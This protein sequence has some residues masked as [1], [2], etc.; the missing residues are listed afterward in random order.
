MGYIGALK[1]GLV[2]LDRMMRTQNEKQQ[3]VFDQSR[4]FDLRTRLDT[5]TGADADVDRLLSEVLGIECAGCS[6]DAESSR[7]LVDQLLPHARLQV[8]YDVSGILPGA[9]LHDGAHRYSAVAPTVP[10]AILRVLAEA[11][12]KRE[13]RDEDDG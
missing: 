12:I 1:M 3:Q 8:G 9:V 5:I 4:L 7:K 6:G 10:L 2:R 11:L 13:C